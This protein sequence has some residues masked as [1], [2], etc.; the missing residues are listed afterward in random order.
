LLRRRKERARETAADRSRVP[1]RW[2]A[3]IVDCD[4]RLAE[5]LRLVEQSPAGPLR[6][7]LQE[8]AV[9]ATASVE[10]AVESAVR[11]GQ[12]EA[13]T[14]TM[15]VD[16]ITTAY[17]RSRRDAETAAQR[18]EV[19]QAMTDSVESLRRQHASV[20]RLLNAV[21]QTDERLA[22]VLARLTELV[23]STAELAFRTSDDALDAV[24]ARA[25]SLATEAHALH[26][27][28]DELD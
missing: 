13:L 25:T 26:A 4:G 24:E 14:A 16:G 19:P 28:F 21:D 3:L 11:A 7:R 27:A 18:G 22:A 23:L 17:K 12:V 15:D 2:R 1:V 6:D 10:E 5:L 20:N 8:L 9:G